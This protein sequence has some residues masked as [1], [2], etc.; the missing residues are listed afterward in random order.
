M[1]ANKLGGKGELPESAKVWQLGAKT[2]YV[3]SLLAKGDH[4][5]T[6]NDGGFAV[7]RDMKTGDQA[8]ETR[9][10]AEV[11]ASPLLIDGKMYIFG[12][13]GDVTVIEASPDKAKVLARNK[14]GE[15]VFSSPALADGRLYV[16]GAKHL[17]CIGM[18]KGK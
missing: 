4:L 18:P 14:L 3:P 11:S 5:Y 9:L 1:V 2:P 10:P 6:V 17:F 7:C 16:R 13:R 12:E 15:A 8:W